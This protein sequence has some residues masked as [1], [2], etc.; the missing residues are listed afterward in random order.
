M[1]D[2][3]RVLL[4]HCIPNDHSRQVVSEYYIDRVFAEHDGIHAA[5]HQAFHVRA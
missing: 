4:G 5:G 1:L 3:L 2:D